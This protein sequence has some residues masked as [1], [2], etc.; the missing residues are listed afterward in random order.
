MAAP[1]MKNALLASSTILLPY[2]C[3]GSP[4][5]RQ[6]IHAPNTVSE[7][8]QDDSTIKIVLKRGEDISIMT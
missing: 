4:A 8:A 5:T 2:S 3:D 6:P 7:V 1:A